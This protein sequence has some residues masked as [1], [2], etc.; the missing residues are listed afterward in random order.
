MAALEARAAGLVVV[1]RRGTG[2]EEFVTDGVD[3]LLVDDDAG[4]ARALA[5]LVHEPELL[6]RLQSR[7]RAV[8]PVLGWSHTLG[9]ADRLYARARAL[10]GLPG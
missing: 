8:R 10:R 2:I 5:G 7:S 6:A 4:M 1:A 3:G 9:A